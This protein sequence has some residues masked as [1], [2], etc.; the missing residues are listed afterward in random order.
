MSTFQERLNEV[1]DARFSGSQ[2]SLADAINTDPSTV[3]KWFSGSRAPRDP[4]VRAICQ[5]ANVSYAWLT[6]GEGEMDA[7]APSGLADA[8]A[9][10]S[11]MALDDPD[12]IGIVLQALAR[13]GPDYIRAAYDLAQRFHAECAAIKAEKKDEE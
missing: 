2:R 3:S 1:V 8:L 12:N 5:V 7:P 4:T 11:D 13:L 6:T 10:L 9:T